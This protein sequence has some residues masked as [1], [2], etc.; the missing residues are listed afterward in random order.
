VHNPAVMPFVFFVGDECKFPA[1][2]HS[3]RCLY[4]CYPTIMSPRG[5]NS[6]TVLRKAYK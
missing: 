6:S 2:I 5:H 4:V 1:R 3:L